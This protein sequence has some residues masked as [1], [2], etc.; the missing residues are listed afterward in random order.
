MPHCKE[1]LTNED[2]D[3]YQKIYNEKSW[4][5]WLNHIGT[6][7]V[8]VVGFC[9]NMLCL[10]VLCRR[11]LRRNSY[12]QYLIALAIVDTGAILSEVLVASDELYQ[13]RSDKRTLLQH[14]NLTCKLYYYIR[15]IFYSMS[16]WI[17]VALAIE[18][19]VAI[20]FP[21][22]SKHICSV[23]NAR[24]I[25]FIVLIFSMT[26]Q[27]YHTIVK[28]LDCGPTSSSS[29]A[30]STSVSSFKPNITTTLL[31]LSLTTA[32]TIT[33]TVT[34]GTTCRCKTLPAYAKIDIVMTIYVWRLVLMLLV[35]SS[36]IISVNILIMN[37]LYSESSLVDHKTRT[38]Q[39]K[40][41]I[42]LYKISKML[43]IVSSVYLVLHVPGS[44]LEV[45]KFIF[46]HA[47]QICNSKLRYYIYI[48][49]DIFD[50]LT[51]FNYGINFYL[52][53]ISG[54]HI[55]LELLRAIDISKRNRANHRQ[56]SSFFS[57]SYI[58]LSKN[59]H[60]NHNNHS[61]FNHNTS[62][63]PKPSL[64]RLSSC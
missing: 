11:R 62:T 42:L 44:L 25:I 55:R 60:Y 20:K 2:Y 48:T 51:N 40:K 63:A 10:V 23:V 47:L 50:L 22:W 13:Y 58:H 36:I 15:Y 33:S 37:Q 64:Q 19:L 57:S 1:N 9:G 59:H 6:F 61:N 28:G 34:S 24:R 29:S 39:R 21:L 53:I 38:N 16:S 31:D 45:L 3:Y 27:S 43:V 56:R 12:T 26:I 41:L 17:I 14:T 54:K 35:P 7:A 49:H 4:A 52:Y 32:T 46:V 18:R 30:T 8:F 5:W